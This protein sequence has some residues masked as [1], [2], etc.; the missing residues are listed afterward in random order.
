MVKEQFDVIKGMQACDAWKKL[1]KIHGSPT[2]SVIYSHSLKTVT[3]TLNQQN[4]LGSIAKLKSYFEHLDTVAISKV[5][6]AAASKCLHDY[7][8][9]GDVDDDTASSH[10]K[11]S[12]SSSSTNSSNSLTGSG[13][14]ALT[15]DH[16]QDTII[17]EYERLNPQFAGQLT[18]VKRD[19][20]NTPSFQQQQRPCPLQ[21]QQQ[22]EQ[23]EQQDQQQQ[24]PSS[25]C[26]KK[27]KKQQQQRGT[28]GGI[29]RDAG[30]S[31]GNHGGNHPHGHSHF[32][33]VAS[34]ITPPGPI[35][36][37]SKHTLEED[38]CPK[39]LDAK[40]LNIETTAA[41]VD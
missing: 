7:S 28:R 39:A 20:T 6:E 5:W 11:K 10:S 1:I 16:V 24:A 26:N 17:V 21:R 19:G 9:L 22:H 23:Q 15:L 14:P 4:P 30:N 2:L 29:D 27:G 32:A 36:S 31:G 8:H 41:E 34:T 12:G 3:F 37:S 18:A 33:S 13:K 40:A 25:N 38:D 35:A